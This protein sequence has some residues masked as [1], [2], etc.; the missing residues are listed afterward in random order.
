MISDQSPN[1]L[2]LN[3]AAYLQ[4]AYNLSAED[5]G[6]QTG[7]YLSRRKTSMQNPISDNRTLGVTDSYSQ[8][9]HNSLRGVQT[10]CSSLSGVQTEKD[11][12]ANATLWRKADLLYRLNQLVT[13]NPILVYDELQELKRLTSLRGLVRLPDNIG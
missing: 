7:G 12:T 10:L 3:Q 8:T 6:M 2:I 9:L 4:S 5:I 13:R 11:S 1:P